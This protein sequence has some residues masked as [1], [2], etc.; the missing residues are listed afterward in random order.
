MLWSS[1]GWSF[2][3]FVSSQS[4][5]TRKRI[6][7]RCLFFTIE[8]L[9]Q[10]SRWLWVHCISLYIITSA[11][12]A[13]LYFEYKTIAKKRLAFIAASSSKPS[14]FTVLMRAVPQSPDQSYSKTVRQYFTNYYAPS[15]MS[16]LMVYRDGLIQR[17]LV[18]RFVLFLQHVGLIILL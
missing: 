2:A 17:L 6:W 10:R 7:S 15:Y 11:A 16:H 1:P 14:H 3:A 13:L 9:N 18:M 12:C 8:N 4:W 5:R